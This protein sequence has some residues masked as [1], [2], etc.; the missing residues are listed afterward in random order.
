LNIVGSEYI[1]PVPDP[2]LSPP[3]TP[4]SEHR[5]DSATQEPAYREHVTGGLVLHPADAPYFRPAYPPNGQHPYYY[6]PAPYGAYPFYPNYAGYYGYP[7]YP[8]Y[9]Y[10]YPY[11]YPYPAPPAR[12][13]R[14]GYLLGVS[15]ASFICSILVLL[16][17][18]VSLMLLALVTLVPASQTTGADQL[19]SSDVLFTALGVAGIVGGGFSLYHSIRSL[20]LK[21]PSGEFK[22]PWFWLF[23]VLYIA[24]LVLAGFMASSGNAVSDPPL[25]ILLIALAGILPALT[26]LALALRRLHFPRNAPWPTTWRRFTLAIVSGATV[27][28]LLASIFELVL[29]A[30]LA[31]S[32]GIT[33]LT[34]IDNPNAPIPNDPRA[35]MF[36]L[37]LVSV[38][39]PL[40][41][42]TVKPLAVV[43]LIGRIRSAAE[44]FI[45]GMSCGIGFDL[46]ETSGYISM[47]YKDWLDVALQR[48][49][50]GL[51]HGLGA[52]MVALGWYLL[53]HRQERRHS[54][55]LAL[56][57][58]AY[59][60][61]QHALWNGSFVL[62]LLPAPVGPYLSN[63][64]LH[65][66]P[67]NLPSFIIVYVIASVIM[68]VFL[69]FVTG[70]LRGKSSPPAAPPSSG[71]TEQRR[72]PSA[73]AFSG[74]QHVGAK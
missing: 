24:L 51:L 5:D 63:G 9:H 27:A 72:Q 54:V 28:I 10:P 73:S 39:A 59:A 43:V 15:I 11:Y 46:I 56:C 37:V 3:Q 12:P 42:E 50:A 31:V 49:T 16:G 69:F 32:L 44:A 20:F 41:E 66:G 67:L 53:T 38:I 18:A 26:I 6:H 21:K 13:K 2:R 62:Q 35:I 60:I 19:F 34:S 30:V 36:L 58:W 40:V 47:G 55:L 4:P 22:L 48:S 23:L 45:L 29:T 33:N 74:I 68:L 52:G 64:N 70:K 65:L 7:G 8:P 57:C 1:G 14:D 71:S 61:L 25:T 17:G